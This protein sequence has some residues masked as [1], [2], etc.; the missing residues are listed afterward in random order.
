MDK[1]RKNYSSFFKRHFR[2][3]IANNTVSDILKISSFSNNEHFESGDD[4]ILANI[5]KLRIIRK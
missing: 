5:R 4:E 2:R 1:K 3:I